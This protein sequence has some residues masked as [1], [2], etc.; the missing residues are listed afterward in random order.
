MISADKKYILLQIASLK[1]NFFIFMII[2]LFS[3]VNKICLLN[4]NFIRTIRE[5]L[6]VWHAKYW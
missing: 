2:F 1:Y 3:A 4:L 5:H 6:V